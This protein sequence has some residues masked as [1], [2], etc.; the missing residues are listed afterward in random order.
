MPG[1]LAL[2][3]ATALTAEPTAAGVLPAPEPATSARPARAGA[4]VLVPFVSVVGPERRLVLG[5]SVGL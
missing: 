2:V 5:L 1:M 3:L 4:P